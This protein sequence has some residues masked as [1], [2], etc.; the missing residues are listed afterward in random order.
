[1][2]SM[3]RRMV[4]PMSRQCS[5]LLMLTLAASPV[6]AVAQ[7]GDFSGLVDIGSG[8]KMY[9]DCRG[10]GSPTVVIVAGGKASA[11]DWTKS[12]P[13]QVNVFSAVARFTR[14]CTYDRPGTPVGD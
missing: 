9:L 5:L 11:V 3:R 1:M 6:S 8:R 4:H 2:M 12:E 10:T 13:G 7:S 14:V